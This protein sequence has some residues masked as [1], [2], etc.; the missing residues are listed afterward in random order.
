MSVSKTGSK[1][2]KK[3]IPSLSISRQ[4]WGIIGFAS[5]GHEPSDHGSFKGTRIIRS[6]LVV[7]KPYDVMWIFAELR[8]MVEYKTVAIGKK[9][10]AI[11][12]R[13][14]SLTSSRCGYQKKENRYGRTFKLKRC[15]FQC[16][17]I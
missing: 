10:T 5:F 13:Y 16:M 14:P 7:S 11:D 4:Q 1:S 17:R 15:G 6:Q 9:V 8:S 2:Q 12:P 3:H